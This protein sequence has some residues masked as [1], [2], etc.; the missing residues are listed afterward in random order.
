MTHLI[1]LYPADKKSTY[2]DLQWRIGNFKPAVKL[3]K[4]CWFVS[5]A[6]SSDALLADLSEY[7]DR[8]DDKLLVCE[9]KCWNHLNFLLEDMNK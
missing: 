5:T 4:N 7:I 8:D 1:L 3:E 9:V 2:R 6:K